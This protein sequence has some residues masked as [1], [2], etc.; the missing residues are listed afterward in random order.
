MTQVSTFERR[1]S[2]NAPCHDMCGGKYLKKYMDTCAVWTAL[3][4]C[5]DWKYP[6]CLIE[7]K[8][9]VNCMK[10]WQ[11]LFNTTDRQTDRQT[12][13]TEW[14]KYLTMNVTR[15]R[16]IL[17][18]E[19]YNVTVEQSVMNAIESVTW[20]GWHWQGVMKGCWGSVCRET[21]PSTEGTWMW[22]NTV[23]L[24]TTSNTHSP[25]YSATHNHW[26]RWFNG[27][28]RERGAHWWC[29]HLVNASEAATMK[30]TCHISNCG[31][32][33]RDKGTVWPPTLALYSN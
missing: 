26:L 9:A 4:V 21:G 29:S 27:R 5:T 16:Q 1:S 19:L 10:I 33:G 7:A 14:L 32:Y 6:Q 18:G 3:Y 17:L 30:V 28:G 25:Q 11:Q 31:S 22:T 15:C 2:Q 24:S 8:C 23:Q 13:M 20:Q 12:D